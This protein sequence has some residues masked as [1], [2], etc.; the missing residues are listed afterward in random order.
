MQAEKIKTKE[1]SHSD[2]AHFLY[3][4]F[5]IVTI[6]CVTKGDK[7]I[8]NEYAIRVEQLLRRTIIVRSNSLEEAIDTITTAVENNEIIL[9]GIDDFSEQN[10]KPSE[11]FD[12]GVVPKNRDVSY[13]EHYHC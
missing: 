2:V 6:K 9:D 7:T 3:T 11:L 1:M 10:I 4:I 5:N 12:G 8:M 13:Y